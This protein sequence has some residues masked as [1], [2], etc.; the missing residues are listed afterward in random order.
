[1]PT[2]PATAKVPTAAL[3]NVAW[4]LSADTRSP[5]VP[6][7]PVPPGGHPVL[8]GTMPARLLALL[9]LL[10]HRP[11]KT[12]PAM[13]ATPKTPPRA[14][15]TERF[16]PRPPPPLTAMGTSWV[17]P[18]EQDTWAWPEGTPS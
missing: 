11:V 15:T 12:A 2:A 3:P 10:A 18:W 16:A 5:Q 6:V 1:M 13:A 8:W 14:M 17:C 9:P 4:E 7:A